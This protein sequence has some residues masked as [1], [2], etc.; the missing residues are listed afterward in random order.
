MGIS[1][2]DERDFDLEIA[3]CASF[4]ELCDAIDLIEESEGGHIV[5]SSG[6]PIKT[7][8]MQGFISGIE[9]LNDDTLCR[10]YEFLLTHANELTSR[11][12]IRQK[13]LELLKARLSG[14]GI[15]ILD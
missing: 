8:Y 4:S 10:T 6:K 11:Y 13:Y 3:Q 14:L 1:I 7:R 15:N 5:S 12:G 2:P 9:H